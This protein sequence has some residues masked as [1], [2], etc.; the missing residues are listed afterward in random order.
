MKL[1][2]LLAIYI[3]K[4]IWL[5]CALSTAE[6]AVYAVLIAALIML[7]LAQ[8]A[9]MSL[10]YRK[11]RFELKKLLGA[12]ALNVA[13]PLIYSVVFLIPWPTKLFN[14]FVCIMLAF[15]SVAAVIAVCW[16][17]CFVLSRDGLCILREPKKHPA[18][19]GSTVT[20]G[21]IALA[22]N[23]IWFVSIAGMAAAENW[24]VF[25]MVIFVFITDFLLETLLTLCL[26]AAH[27]RALSPK[28]EETAVP[29]DPFTMK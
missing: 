9:V 28:V 7:A 12:S 18:V 14:I 22:T 29:I 1:I 20:L 8:G 21:L 23:L 27:L 15:I 4:G 13:L 2:L 19:L 25:I 3:L 26:A 24:H 6:P 10:I 16:L 11:G 5:Y 17:S